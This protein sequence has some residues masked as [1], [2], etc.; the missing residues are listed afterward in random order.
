MALL[1]RHVVSLSRMRYGSERGNI[2]VAKVPRPIGNWSKR[3][4]MPSQSIRSPR[5]AFAWLQG[6]YG[7]ENSGIEKPS[8]GLTAFLECKLAIRLSRKCPP[9]PRA[10]AEPTRINFERARVIATFT[11]RQS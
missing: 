4:K 3:I 5:T 7:S 1:E 11:R 10:D 6:H 2:L 9:L 8:T